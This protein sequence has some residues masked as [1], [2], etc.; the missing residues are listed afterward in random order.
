M[1]PW[2]K[3]ALDARVDRTASDM[4]R[5]NALK[6][7]STVWCALDRIDVYVHA[8]ARRLREGP[9]ELLHELH[10]EL[11]TFSLFRGT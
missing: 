10:V 1:S 8:D 6:T 3:D 9:E 5:P 11:P 2:W 4:A 7:A